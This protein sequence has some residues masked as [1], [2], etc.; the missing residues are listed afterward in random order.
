MFSF[1]FDNFLTRKIRQ[2]EEASSYASP[3]GFHA[4]CNEKM[5]GTG[6]HISYITTFFY[7]QEL[8]VL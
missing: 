3:A 4:Q 8:T 6:S 7:F 5:G 1:A 2:S